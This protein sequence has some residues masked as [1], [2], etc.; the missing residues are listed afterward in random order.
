MLESSDKLETQN[1]LT[2]SQFRKEQKELFFDTVKL[3]VYS[4]IMGLS[5]FIKPSDH[6]KE[7]ALVNYICEWKLWS[8]QK[9]DLEK[10]ANY[11]IYW[12]DERTQ[13]V[14]INRQLWTRKLKY[15]LDNYWKNIS[16]ILVEIK[17]KEDEMRPKQNV[18][19]KKED[20]WVLDWLAGWIKD[21]YNYWADKLS[22]LRDGIK[23]LVPTP[24]KD[25]VKTNLF[26]P[27]KQKNT[28]NIYEMYKN[29]KWSE[30]PAFLPFYLAMQ[31]YNKQK[32][33]LWNS[34]YLTIVDYSKPVSQKRLYVINMSTST[35]ENCVPTWHGQNSGNTQTTSKFSNIDKSKQTSI[36]FFRTPLWLQSNSKWSWKW[37]FLKWVE[38]SND[39]ASARWIAVHPVRSF[40]YS[41]TENGHRAWDSTSEGCITIRS[42][43]NPSDIM[44]K[45]KWDSLIYSYYPDMSYLNKSTMIK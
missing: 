22:D 25:W 30:K 1:K 12:S 41:R 24:V 31:W 4:I 40:F 39:K 19:L 14:P 27:E 23:S 38:Y 11:I 20:K 42:V 5:L 3:Q 36:G 34:K 32:D 7:N 29:L 33:R 2:E 17:K 35:V 44:N 8:N 18:V 43:D 45:I 13:K 10:M 21:V 28:E 26:S 16:T 6:G 9:K 37:L 15:I